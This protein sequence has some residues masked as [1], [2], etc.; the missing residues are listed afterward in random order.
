M[1][2][3]TPENAPAAICAH[4]QTPM[5]IDDVQTAAAGIVELADE[6][7][8]NAARV[9]GIELGHDISSFDLLVTGGGGA[10]HAARIAEKLD[11]ARIIV[12]QNAG[13]GSAVGFLRSPV[14]FEAA[15]SLMEPLADIDAT[16]LS[17]RVTTQIAHVRA[18]VEEAVPADRILT[19]AKIEMRYQ[20]QGLEIVLEQAADADFAIDPAQ[21]EA[22][23]ITRYRSLVGF[24]LKDIPLDLVSVSVTARENRSLGTPP[25]TPGAQPG[26]PALRQV[27]DLGEKEHIAYRVLDR[28]C[29][30]RDVTQGPAIVTEDQTTT[31][32]RP[33]WS[34]HASDAGHLVLER[35]AP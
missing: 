21:L 32:V 25:V 28:A 12:P 15:I 5:G 29:V 24:T 10:L 30:G 17:D 13:V 22:E 14:A 4:V 33:G 20:G 11:I 8:A 35:H 16:A 9:H 23:F 34:V 6:T 2:S 7:M 27:F 18:I 19:T 31:L 26:A 1:I 3:L